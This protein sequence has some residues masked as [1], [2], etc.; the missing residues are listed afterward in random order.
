MSCDLTP[1][2]T[3]FR[4]YQD[5]SVIMKERPYAMEPS[6]KVGK[7]SASSKSRAPDC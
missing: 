5:K 2:L 6:F 4:S 7:S 3:L 1:L